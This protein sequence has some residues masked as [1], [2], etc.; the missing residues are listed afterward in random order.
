MTQEAYDLAVWLESFI[1]K[2][3]NESKENTLNWSLNE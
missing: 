1:K 3:I 2:F